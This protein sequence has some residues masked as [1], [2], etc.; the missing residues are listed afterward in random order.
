MNYEMLHIPSG[1]RAREKKAF[2]DILQCIHEKKS[3]VFDAGAG[4]GKTY[5]LVQ[6]LK[7]V[8][9]QKGQNLKIHNQKILCITYTNIAANEIKER[10]GSTTLID[11]STIHDCVWGIIS[12]HQKQLVSIHRKKMLDELSTIKRLFETENWAKKYQCLLELEKDLLQKMIDDKK[13]YYYKHKQ[14]NA[15]SFRKAFSNIN[16]RFPDLLTNV[17]DF[18]KV[19]NYL[20]KMQRY[21][22]TI[23]KIDEEDIKFIKVKY[24]VRFNADRLEKMRISHDTLLEYTKKIIDINDILKQMICDQYPFVLVDEYQDTSPL[25]I[26]SLN[27]ISEY[28][29]KIDHTFLVGY[30]GDVKQNIYEEGV[31]TNLR[32]IHKGL[33]RIEK[34]FNRRCSPQIISIANKIR[35]DGLNQESIY[36]DFP[37]SNIIFHHI[38]IDRQEVINAYIERWNINERNKLHCFE[39][40]NEQVAEQSGFSDIYNFFKYSKWYSSGKH[41]EFLRDHILSLDENKLGI[42]QKILFRI[43]DFKYKLQQH[44]TMLM[45]IFQEAEMKDINIST[46]RNLTMKL[47]NI[48]GKNLREYIINIFDAYGKG[49]TKYDKCV[50]YIVAEEINSYEE[51]KQFVLDHLYYFTDDE[52]VS[53]EDIQKNEKEVDDFFGIN[54]KI[55]DLWY[56]FI[57]DNTAGKV[58]YHTYHGT[59]GREFDNVIIFMNSKFGRK[60]NYFGN[61]LKV[62][63]DKN[64]QQ[65]KGT[66]IETARN[67]LYVAITRA[68]KNL[69]IVYLDELGEPLQAVQ[70]VFGSIKKKL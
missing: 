9:K 12:P 63:T 42:V 28:A 54:M 67:L 69:C 62:L 22:K 26:E 43:L 45:E 51:L 16:E 1:N 4:A 64:E 37:N 59:K 36:E 17:N 41:Y 70:A 40:T 6:T 65:E 53:A 18:K 14:D 46:L 47:Q 32:H 8:I 31:G 11:V 5:T 66:D 33:E 48:V 3:W 34:V 68:T 39:L 55:F 49:D 44:C 52:E 58:I 13:D 2:D 50:E 35:N 7:L 25:V 29:K 27:M 19:M 61:L 15:S 20:F 38:K 60:N 57:I 10:L 21:E 30:Y 56:N 24:D 23:T